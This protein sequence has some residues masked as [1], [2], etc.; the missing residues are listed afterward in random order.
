MKNLEVVPNN[1]LIVSKYN[2]AHPASDQLF[3]IE[4]NWSLGD[5]KRNFVLIVEDMQKDYAPYTSTTFYQTASNSWN[6]SVS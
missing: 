2:P 5:H 1:G 6:V 4:A 3:K